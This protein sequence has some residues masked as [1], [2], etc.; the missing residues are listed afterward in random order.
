MLNL[1]ECFQVAML[2]VTQ[3]YSGLSQHIGRKSANEPRR[4]ALLVSYGD[5]V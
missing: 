3:I 4:P 2:V 1:Q 5:D